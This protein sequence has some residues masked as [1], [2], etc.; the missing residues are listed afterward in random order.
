MLVS[1]HIVGA[2]KP[3]GT[4]GESRGISNRQTTPTNQHICCKYT[5]VHM[6]SWQTY[7]Y[8]D[9]TNV[10]LK[11][12]T[13]SKIELSQKS[14]TQ[15]NRQRKFKRTSGFNMWKSIANFYY[16]KSYSSW[17]TL[18]DVHHIAVWVLSGQLGSALAQ[19][20]YSFFQFDIW[21]F[22]LKKERP[23]LNF[24]ARELRSSVAGYRVRSAKV[25]T[26]HESSR[27][28]MKFEILK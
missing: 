23:F 17:L 4:S 8:K 3:I 16:F 27:Y 19:N 10:E 7:K 26:T 6:C 28:H 2:P 14:V 25:R 24:S 12:K 20:C 5:H 15:T 9:D 1:S 22:S 11:K 18:D 13:I 21:I